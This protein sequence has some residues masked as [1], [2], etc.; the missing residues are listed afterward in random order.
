MVN[1]AKF[2]RFT[3]LDVR[4]VVHPF[5]TQLILFIARAKMDPQF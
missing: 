5:P 1:P 2:L 3:E 4:V